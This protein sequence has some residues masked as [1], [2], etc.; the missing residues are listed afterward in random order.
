MALLITVEEII[1][2]LDLDKVAEAIIVDPESKTEILG[3]E[4]EEVKRLVISAATKWLLGDLKYLEEDTL[5]IESPFTVDFN[6]IAT[7]GIID[8]GAK[9]NEKHYSSKYRGKTV[10]ADWKSASGAL[11]KAWQDRLT[12]SYQ[13]A[14]YA[15]VHKAELVSYRG[16]SR[17]G[18]TRELLIEV[19]PF[20]LDL[21]AR[22]FTQVGGMITSLMDS[23]A[24][25]YPMHK[26]S[27]CGQYGTTCP[28]LDDCTGDKAPRYSLNSADLIISYSSAERFL[29]CPEKYR[30]LSQTE[31]RGLDGSE[32]TRTGAAF[33]RG[34]AEL[35][36]QSFEKYGDSL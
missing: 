26:P 11:D 35:Y 13:W 23:G 16:V 8:L 30:R 21:A 9:I 7:R 10:V 18:T 31:N 36:L 19:S 15:S 4:V 25:V 29:T 5:L 34:I 12:Q 17:T 33:H 22:H 27:A 1:A 24:E 14:L 2:S 28:F 20:H 3:F 6:G 32:S